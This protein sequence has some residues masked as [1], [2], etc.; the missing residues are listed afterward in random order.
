MPQKQTKNVKLGVDFPECTHSIIYHTTKRDSYQPSISICIESSPKL[1]TKKH[2]AFEA[3]GIGRDVMG[4]SHSDGL[5]HGAQKNCSQDTEVLCQKVTESERLQS[6][7]KVLL[8]LK[9][10]CNYH[11]DYLSR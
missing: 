10:V 2:I 11:K 1:N 3:E 9:A 4:R 6:G 8:I 7:E 5:L